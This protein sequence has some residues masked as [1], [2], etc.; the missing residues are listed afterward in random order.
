M[1][2]F[3]TSLTFVRGES[4][5]TSVTVGNSAPVIGT[6]PADGSYAT[7]PTNVGSDVTFTVT[8]TDGNNESYYIAVCKTDSVTPH[9]GAAPTCATD[10]TWC[11]STNP[12]ASASQASCA[13]TALAGDAQSNAWYV[14]VCDSNA[15]SSSCSTPG[16]QNLGDANQGSPFKVNHAAVFDAYSNDGPKNPG[17]AITF[18]TNTSTLDNDN[19][20]TPDTVKLLVC[21]TAGVS[22]GDCDGGASDRWCISDSWVANNPSCSN[23]LTAPVADDTYNAYVYVIDSHNFV[24]AGTNQGSNSTFTVNNVAPVVSAVT[25]NGG[26]AITL[27]E[28]ST[29]NVVLGATVTDT[30]G[31]SEIST[32]LGYAYRSGKGYGLCDTSGEADDNFCYPE[33]SCS[34]SDCS[35]SVATYTCTAA[36]QYHADPTDT[37]TQYPDDTWKDTIK[38]TDDD[39][40]SHNLEVTS[41]VEMESKLT[42]DVSA[43]IAY[44]SLSVGGK[45]DPLDKT[46][47]VTA[48]GNVGL[49]E[50]LSGADMSDGNDHTIA[51]GKQV[52]ALASSTAYASGTALTTSPDEAELNCQKTIAYA[53]PKTKDTW[54]GIEIPTNTFPAV[55][56]GTNT[57]TAVKGETANW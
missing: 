32:V 39:T 23:A 33:V 12:V 31:C 19:D 5:T 51:V 2:L 50:E 41:G 54:W 17:S 28:S 49:D 16:A 21:K 15:S 13:Y 20:T 10:Q 18:S 24:D 35:G 37:A 57:V 8:A 6:G 36:I 53:T 45:N 48:T 30:N 38:A 52:W 40:A 29:K 44:G 22:A 56:S 43:S 34:T 42:M 1:V 25:I 7:L 3:L 47:T 14:F 55:Y 11:V 9:N 26:S 27:T 4:V 46:T